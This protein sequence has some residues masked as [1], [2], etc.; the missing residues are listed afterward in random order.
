MLLVHGAS[1][2]SWSHQ[3][4]PLADL[5][6]AAD[7]RGGRAPAVRRAWTRPPGRPSPFLA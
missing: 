6:L 7:R 2:R 1:C 4:L 3:N 5:A